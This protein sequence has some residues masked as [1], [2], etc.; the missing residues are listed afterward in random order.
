MNLNPLSP[1]RLCRIA[2]FAISS[3]CLS[4]AQDSAAPKTEKPAQ[5]SNK[6]APK[7]SGSDFIRYRET[8]DDARLETAVKTYG[9]KSGV[10]VDLVGVVHIADKTYYQD[11]NEKLGTYDAVL[12]ELV[13]DPKALLAKGK[14]KEAPNPLRNL[15]KMAGS[16]LRLDFQLD[17]INYDRPNFVHADLSVEEFAQRQNNRGENL[18][19]LLGRAMRMEREG[20]L[21]GAESAQDISLPELLSALSGADGA[22]SLKILM[23]KV[24]DGAEEMMESFEGQDG[25]VIL[26]ERNKVVSAKLKESVDGGKK[27]LAIFYGAGHLPGIE[28]LLKEGGYAC[29]QETW[30]PAWKMKK[31]VPKTKSEPKAEQ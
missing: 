5:P 23:A 29:Q 11:L 25:T 7:K 31:P 18:M 2:L 10:T 13:G 1:F 6:E 26:T 15:Q 16:M 4:S 22:D 20:K 21:P 3:A 30:M 12:Y 9:A 24:F 14:E 8:E 17:N 28:A 27:H 19:S